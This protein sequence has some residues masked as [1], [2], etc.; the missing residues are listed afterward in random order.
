MNICN[1]IA[2]VPGIQT[3]TNNDTE[4][5]LF[6]FFASGDI[7]LADP[8]VDPSDDTL[9]VR[10]REGMGDGDAVMTKRRK[11]KEKHP[12]ITRLAKHLKC[13]FLFSFI[14]LSI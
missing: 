12:S 1:K 13:F 3:P 8:G 5:R 9:G 7:S 6:T 14:A 4:K 2:S 11:K 10:R